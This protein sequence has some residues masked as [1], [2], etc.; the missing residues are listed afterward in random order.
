MKTSYYMSAAL[1]AGRE[2]GKLAIVQISQG[3]PR[4]KYC[5][6]DYNLAGITPEYDRHAGHSAEELRRQYRAQLDDY[7]VDNIRADFADLAEMMRA[8]GSQ[9]EPVLCCHEKD[10]STCHRR[11]FAEWWQEKTG[12]TI[13]EL[14]LSS[15]AQSRAILTPAFAEYA[16]G[17]KVAAKVAAYFDHDCATCRRE[18]WTPAPKREAKPET[19]TPER[20][21]ALA[22]L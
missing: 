13:P 6:P 14:D 3:L 21:N 8:D 4:W 19:S 5:Q 11:W 2:A 16:C 7:G 17:C 22:A 12:E 9:A 18:K 20:F 10:G 15:R 1:R